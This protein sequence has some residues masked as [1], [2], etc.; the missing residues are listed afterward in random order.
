MVCKNSRKESPRPLD[1]A[2]RIGQ[3]GDSLSSENVEDPTSY[4]DSAYPSDPSGKAAPPYV[5]K[6]IPNLIPPLTYGAFSNKILH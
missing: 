4:E 3:H 6:T 1:I 2:S 5:V